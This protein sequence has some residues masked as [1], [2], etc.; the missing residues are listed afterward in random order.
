MENMLGIAN[1]APRLDFRV[2]VIFKDS[3]KIGP[4]LL[5]GLSSYC[6]ATHL[7]MDDAPQAKKEE[8]DLFVYVSSCDGL[9]AIPRHLV[10]RAL[11]LVDGINDHVIRQAMTY[12]WVF[13]ATES[14]AANMRSAGIINVWGLGV[15][16]LGPSASGT[17]ESVLLN[18]DTPLHSMEATVLNT[19][20]TVP[21]MRSQYFLHPRPEIVELVPLTARR[22]LD[23]GCAAGR[24][25]QTL[26]SRQQCLVHGVEM[27]PIAANQARSV[28]DAVYEGDIQ[29]VLDQLPDRFFDCIV[30]A[31]VLEHTIDPWNTLRQLTGKLAAN[32]ES[33][34]VLSIPNAAHWSVVLPLLAGQW[35]YMDE[36]ILD[37]THL[38]FFTPSSV[39]AM[40]KA[41]GLRVIDTRATIVPVPSEAESR[42]EGLLQPW[43]ASRLAEIFQVLC[44]C[45]PAATA[46]S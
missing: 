1:M 13:T 42:L 30:L 28:L 40:V 7:R 22:I 44:V 33:T 5:S 17:R 10:P 43:R 25:G 32:P 15:A 6:C 11:W 29:G 14:D 26:K 41:A 20:W 12:D 19:I 35:E 23:V 45:G 31:D 39:I 9:E 36:G 24:L 8:Y 34:M 4:D 38:R 16:G 18:A 27:H 37:R 3:L 21:G 2:G 46:G